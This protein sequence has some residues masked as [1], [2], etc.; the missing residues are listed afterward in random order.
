[1]DKPARN[2]QTVEER[3]LTLLLAVRMGVLG[4]MTS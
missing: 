3:T 1:M 4:M 2:K